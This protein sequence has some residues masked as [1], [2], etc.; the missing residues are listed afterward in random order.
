MK[1]TS[2][3]E[4]R[5]EN[6]EPISP[7]EKGEL[8]RLEKIVEK[9]FYDGAMALKEIR[10]KRLYRE[11]FKT[12]EAYCQDKWGFT[13]QR[14]R[15]LIEAGETIELLPA[16]C[17]TICKENLSNSLTVSAVTELAKVSQEQ[18]PA[19]LKAAAAQ[20]KV[21]AE[22]IRRVIPVRP[23]KT[24][25]KSNLPKRED[26]EK[27]V[28][29]TGLEIPPESLALWQRGEADE[30]RELVGQLQSIKRKLE[31]RRESNDSLYVECDLQ[32]AVAWLTQSIKEIECAIP[33][34]VCWQCNGKTPKGCEV[35]S[36]PRGR[37]LQN[38]RGF[39]SKHY[40]NQNCPEEIKQLRKGK[41]GE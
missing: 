14:A 8:G 4:K 24:P 16:D 7:T 6:L 39:V 30:A 1:P 41:V 9:S 3:I 26:A 25:K 36:G 35:C 11:R 37:K 32:Q 10:D 17:Q 38:G 13:R 27:S 20:G 33:A 15:Q 29:K 19:V 31:A 5:N 23:A 12:F 34:Y 21:T 2:A 22:A 40:W 28:D 18:R